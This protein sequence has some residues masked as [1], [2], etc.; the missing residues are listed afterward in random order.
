M[1]K[2]YD[3]KV[4]IGYDRMLRVQEL[5]D[6]GVVNVPV[7]G[8][9]YKKEDEI[10]KKL[11][12]N[13]VTLNSSD[14]EKIKG[15]I[16]KSK[17][18][19]ISQ[20]E[21]LNKI[22]LFLEERNNLLSQEVQN[23][24]I[25]LYK[26]S[27]LESPYIEKYDGYSEVWA[28]YHINS[29][30]KMDK[31]MFSD[32]FNLYKVYASFDSFEHLTKEN[33]EQILNDLSEK[34]FRGAFKVIKDTSRL[35]SSDQM[36]F[37]A[38]SFDDQKIIYEYLTNLQNMNEISCGIDAGIYSFSTLLASGNFFE[39]TKDVNI[40]NRE[41]LIREFIDC[42]DTSKLAEHLKLDEELLMLVTEKNL[43]RFEI[44]D[45]ETKEFF[46]ERFFEELEI[47]DLSE[48][49]IEK[50]K[51]Y[52]E[53]FLEM[54]SL[55]MDE[56]YSEDYIRSHQDETKWRYVFSYKNFSIEFLEE[57][58]HKSNTFGVDI[59]GNPYITKEIIDK[60]KD[61][62][63]FEK[64]SSNKHL[65]EDIIMAYKEDLDMRR[66]SANSKLSYDFIRENIEDLDI[67][68]L[69]RNKEINFEIKRNLREEFSKLFELEDIVEDFKYRSMKNSE[70][71]IISNIDKF[72]LSQLDK[73][74]NYC[75]ENKRNE[76]AIE[77]DDF[78]KYKELKENYD[79]PTLKENLLNGLIDIK[80]FPN[81]IFESKLFLSNL[82]LSK[83]FDFER[84]PKEL[85]QNE[86]YVKLNEIKCK[87]EEKN[88]EFSFGE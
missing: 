88:V 26:L 78:K 15:D 40:K 84:L 73:L 18:L 4:K 74:T 56:K 13:L 16:I 87:K 58:K 8:I 55:K 57:F 12:Y 63:N 38:T 80:E 28:K 36:C 52:L 68:E 51:D 67:S 85:Q 27:E 53:D 77:S 9:L 25:N 42:L 75:E 47:Q 62:I 19:G 49:Y 61:E 24:G 71:I 72:S 44:Y 45:E 48:A 81:E 46:I 37:Y 50:Y 70:E 54:Q 59:A 31:D 1:Y 35:N 11:I 30:L 69:V 5:I 83:D 10:N 65:T 34:G 39:Y 86:F 20:E 41:L 14:Y 60:F 7:A 29:P 43:K 76:Q 6:L 32:C 33:L 21:M 17:E 3:D 82:L 23:L 66:I 79:L 22:N 2:P 64:L